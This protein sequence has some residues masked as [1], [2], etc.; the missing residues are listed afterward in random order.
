MFFAEVNHVLS[1]IFVLSF[2]CFTLLLTL[3]DHFFDL[4]N[5]WPWFLQYMHAGVLIFHGIDV[6]RE[7][8]S[9]SPSDVFLFRND[10]RFD[11]KAW[12]LCISEMFQLR[13]FVEK[14]VVYEIQ[15]KWHFLARRVL[16]S[17]NKGV[18]EFYVLF[19]LTS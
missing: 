17:L 11:F 8:K 6:R 13:D 4:A 14:L 7:R 2:V 9:V 10:S 19:I 3:G 5:N 15:V 1:N 18:F 12:N 16:K